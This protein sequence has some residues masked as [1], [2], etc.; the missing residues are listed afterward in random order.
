[1]E[2]TEGDFSFDVETTKFRLPNVRWDF[3]VSPPPP[4]PLKLSIYEA[5][6][7]ADPHGFSHV[8]T[9]LDNLFPQLS[10]V[11]TSSVGGYVGDTPPPRFEYTT[12]SIPLS[13][14]LPYEA[15]SV[16][17]RAYLSSALMEKN[18][19][20]ARVVESKH[21]G[22]WRPACQALFELFH[23]GTSPGRLSAA[24]AAGTEAQH[25]EHTGDWDRNYLMYAMIEI[26]MSLTGHHRM[27]N[28]LEGFTTLEMYDEIC[29][30]GNA[31]QDGPAGWRVAYEAPSAVRAREGA[32]ERLGWYLSSAQPASERAASLQ[33]IDADAV[34]SFAPV[35]G[36]GSLETLRSQKLAYLDD[37]DRYRDFAPEDAERSLACTREGELLR[38]NLAQRAGFSAASTQKNVWCNPSWDMSVERTVGDPYPHSGTLVDT[39]VKDFFQIDAWRVYEHERGFENVGRAYKHEN[40][41]SWVY[42]TSSGDPD[43]RAGMYRLVDLPLFRSN[44][45]A[46]QANVRCSLHSYQHQHQHLNPFLFPQDGA[47]HPASNPKFLPGREALLRFRCSD[48]LAAHL[49]VDS[50]THAPYAALGECDFKTDL[51]LESSPTNR[52]AAYYYD[53][54]GEAPSPSP[55]PPPPSPPPPYRFS[56]REVMTRIREAESRVCTSVYYLS[57]ATRCERL[58]VDLTERVLVSFLEPPSPPPAAPLAP[59]LPPPP[60]SPALPDGLRPALITHTQLSTLRL[61]PEGEDHADGFSED[62]PMRA[63]I[64][65]TLR[66]AAVGERAHCAGPSNN[67]RLHCVSGTFASECVSDGRRCGTP[68]ENARDPWAEVRVALRTRSYAWAV[69]LALPRN[70]QLA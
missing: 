67:N 14:K 51:L 58:A 23:E 41:M 39:P 32:A 44:P 52:A 66:A 12:A 59:A 28:Q 10:H 3:D 47:D 13:F 56:Q 45:C 69:R 2:D 62:A 26:E 70:R 24:Y 40:L 16:L 48:A 68:A 7:E 37:C 61:P 43:V 20:G 4:P 17:T 54:L 38:R 42:V 63:V 19:L 1:M 25:V 29:G 50:C 5:L 27:S 21:T 34:A 60:P 55:P 57:Q 31:N 46:S 22:L 18:S 15:R 11:A 6:I 8:R 53:R 36:Y 49:G 30:V 35:V 33:S 65:E 9:K 64:V